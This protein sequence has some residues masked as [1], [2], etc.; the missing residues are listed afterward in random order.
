MPSQPLRLYQGEKQARTRTLQREEEEENAWRVDVKIISLQPA[1]PTGKRCELT[2][3]SVT[4]GKRCELTTQSVTEG[5]RC[6]LTTQSVTE[7]KRCELT[8]QSVTE[9]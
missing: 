3:Q 6:E 8:A 7:G 2:T 1:A 9:G 5:K 4:E